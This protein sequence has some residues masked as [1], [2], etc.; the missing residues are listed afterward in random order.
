[1]GFSP[2]PQ[3]SASF[4]LYADTRPQ[5]P[6]QIPALHHSSSGVKFV[7]CLNI[8]A[9]SAADAPS[10]HE[11]RFLLCT[12][13]AFRKLPIIIRGNALNVKSGLCVG[14]VL[15]RYGSSGR[16]RF[17]FSSVPRVGFCPV[18]GSGSDSLEDG[19]GGSDAEVLSA[20]SG[21][22]LGEDDSGD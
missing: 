6:R 5:L 15:L 20:V 17:P 16:R 2:F 14:P 8:G 18:V 4:V 21:D 12:F 9:L 11:N 7:A 13:I 19:I 22:S 10:L 3:D 1:M